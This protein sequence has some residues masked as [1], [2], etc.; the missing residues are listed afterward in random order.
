MSAW[1]DW[2]SWEIELLPH[3]RQRMLDR[4]FTEVE[5]RVMI[6]DATDISPDDFPGRWVAKTSQGGAPWEVILEPNERQRIIKVVT[7]YPVY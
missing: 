2:W 3:V 5:L 6:E 1:P 4:G 7:A